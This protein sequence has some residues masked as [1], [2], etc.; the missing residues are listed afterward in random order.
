MGKISLGNNIFLGIY[1]QR[2]TME[3]LREAFPSRLI[4]GSGDMAWPPRSPDLTSPFFFWVYLK[5]KVYTD[6]PN[7]LL[8]LQQKIT[9]EIHEINQD[10]LGRLWR[11]LSRRCATML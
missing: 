4:S 11:T 10:V 2:N 3:M 7:T 5:S 6:R 8:E 1:S 9:E